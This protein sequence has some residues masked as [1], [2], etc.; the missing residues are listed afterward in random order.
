MCEK[1]LSTITDY[2]PKGK[3]K[4]VKFEN[5]LGEIWYQIQTQGWLFNRWFR[6]WYNTD[7]GWTPYIPQFDSENEVLE[8]LE[9]ENEKYTN[10][11]LRNSLTITEIS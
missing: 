2:K 11:N 8:F 3:Y 6:C 5:G 7:Y 9:I 4:I 10:N 1:R